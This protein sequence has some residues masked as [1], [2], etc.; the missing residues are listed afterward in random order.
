QGNVYVQDGI[1][2]SSL[3]IVYDKAAP[4]NGGV[5]A[6]DPQMSPDGRLVAFVKDGEIFVASGESP[7]CSRGLMPLTFGGRSNGMTHGLAD[8]VAQEEM[9]R[10]RGFWWS[11]DSSSI[12]FTEV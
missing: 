8:F 5:G 9:D 7:C 12:A 10:Y 6:V 11:L 2:S 1:D 3:R 4:G